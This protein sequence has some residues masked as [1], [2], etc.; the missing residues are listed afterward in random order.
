MGTSYVEFIDKGYWTHDAFLEGLSYLL[1]REFKKLTA[2]QQWQAELIDKWDVA[3]T[4]GFVGCV[5]SYFES[6]DTH[7]KVQLLR[8]TLIQIQERLTSDPNFLTVAELNEN[9]VGQGG[10]IEL[11]LNRFLNI[12]KLTL[13]LIDGK[14]TTD[15][16][17]PI[18]YWN[19]D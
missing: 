9:G 3:A 1:A 10:W 17:S 6:F 16:S 19:V 5:P 18:D 15:A 7:D 8:E 11:N 14:H 2:K 4:A 12:I 13:D